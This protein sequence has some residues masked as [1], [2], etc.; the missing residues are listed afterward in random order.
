MKTLISLFI[1][2]SASTSIASV[3]RLVCIP[4]QNDDVRIEVLFNKAINPKTPFIGS[5]SFG[6]TLIVKEKGFSKSYTNSNV[7]ISPE[8][9]YSDISLRGDAEG[10]YLRLYPQFQGSEFSHYTGQL[11]VN[12]LE[13]RD[14]FNF[15]DS[16]MGPGFSCK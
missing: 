12:D 1:A 4:S 6:A 2:L 7:R 16:G 13:T 14:Y 15:R 5:Y 10:V 11:F 8:T 3:T 9:Y